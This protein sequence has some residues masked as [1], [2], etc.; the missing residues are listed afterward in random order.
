MLHPSYTELMNKINERQ[1]TEDEP[2]IKSRYS[3]V[4][5]AAKRA[6]Q[7]IGGDEPLIEPEDKQAKPLSIAV[8]ELYEG[9]VNILPDDYEPEQDE[10]LF[11]DDASLEEGTGSE[12]TDDAEAAG[13]DGKSEE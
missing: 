1:G 12:E 9:K 10:M 13:A 6:R 11:A 7:L 3:I 8:D 5:A 4:V 2:F